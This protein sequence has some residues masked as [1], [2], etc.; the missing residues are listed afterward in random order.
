MRHTLTE[1]TAMNSENETPRPFWKKRMWMVII[2]AASVLAPGV[3][4]TL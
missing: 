2:R 3:V 4:A 1:N